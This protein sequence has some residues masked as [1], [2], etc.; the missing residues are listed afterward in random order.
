M[1]YM[2]SYIISSGGN[3]Q[4]I[5]CKSEEVVKNGK[6]RRNVRTKQSYFCNNCGRQFVEAD[7]FENYKNAFNKLFCYAAKLVFGISI[8]LQKHGVKHNNSPIERHNGD[9]K[10]MKK[11]C[12]IL[13]VLKKQ[14]NF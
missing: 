12:G 14:N 5:F 8:K 10:D 9:I 1:I 11:Q 7:G 6:R 3:M 4:C 13:G 2:S